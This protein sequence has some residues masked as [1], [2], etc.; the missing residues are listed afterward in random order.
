MDI[1]FWISVDT[2]ISL[3]PIL[4][5]GAVAAQSVTE[6]LNLVKPRPGLV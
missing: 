3:G 5:F 1:R 2:L 4:L 6:M